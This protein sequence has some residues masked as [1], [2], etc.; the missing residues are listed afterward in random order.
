MHGVGQL[1]PARAES[2]FKF[3]I[4]R[5]GGSAVNFE[6]G[7]QVFWNAMRPH[8]VHINERGQM[9]DFRGEAR[10]GRIGMG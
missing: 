3:L 10:I 9:L 2:W 7:G 1:L 4:P 5:L 6:E 8:A